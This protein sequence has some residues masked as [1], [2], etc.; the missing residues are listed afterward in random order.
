MNLTLPHLVNICN[1]KHFYCIKI[2]LL[3]KL[4]QI[5][6][7][8]VVVSFTPFQPQEKLQGL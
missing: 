4:H 1:I 3:H 6:L 7:V 8:A 5:V 2:D